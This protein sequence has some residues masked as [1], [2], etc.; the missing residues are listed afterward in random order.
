MKEYGFIIASVWALSQ[1]EEGK[2]KKKKK[3]LILEEPLNFLNFIAF[4]C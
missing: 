4:V 3:L 1:R 2:R